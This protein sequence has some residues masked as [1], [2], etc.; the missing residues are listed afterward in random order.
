MNERIFLAFIYNERLIVYKL[1]HKIFHRH[2][3]NITTLKT[4]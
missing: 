1:V 2:N 3:P 4:F